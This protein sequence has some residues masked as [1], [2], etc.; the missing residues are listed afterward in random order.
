MSATDGEDVGLVMQSTAI[1]EASSQP[2]D[3]H[4]VFVSFN[5]DREKDFVTFFY[6]FLFFF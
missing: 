5:L 4:F 2:A 3:R 6:L 1:W